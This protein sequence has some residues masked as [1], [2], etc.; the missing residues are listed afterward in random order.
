MRPLLAEQGLVVL[1]DSFPKGV[2]YTLFFISKVPS[3]LWRI[4]P[5]KFVISII[6]THARRCRL[7]IFIYGMEIEHRGNWA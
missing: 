6:L 7:R 4:Q 5:C 3:F 1:L 2:Y